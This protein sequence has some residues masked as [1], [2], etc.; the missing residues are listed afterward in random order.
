MRSQV[1]WPARSRRDKACSNKGAGHIAWRTL[2]ATILMR[3]PAGYEWQ[4]IVQHPRDGLYFEVFMLCLHAFIRFVSNLFPL[5]YH[6]IKPTLHARARTHTHTHT[7]ARARTKRERERERERENRFLW[8]LGPQYKL[9]N[10]VVWCYL[11]PS[12][13]ISCDQS[14]SWCVLLW[15]KKPQQ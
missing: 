5:A 8:N 7:R 14:A 9:L 4:Y 6:S 3:S 10:T 12:G 11:T 2:G 15:K 1:S 13:T